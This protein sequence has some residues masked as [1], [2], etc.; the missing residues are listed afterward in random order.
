MKGLAIVM[1]FPAL[2]A[3][4]EMPTILG[5]ISNRAGSK[6]TFTTVQGDCKANDK[7]VYAQSDSGRIELSG[8]YRM[9]GDDLFVIWSDGDI[10]TYPINTLTLS[11]EMDALVNR[12]R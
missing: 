6:I 4:Q 10:Y 5:S 7:M 1:L 2:A 8:C 9:V 11:S 3:A 12:Q